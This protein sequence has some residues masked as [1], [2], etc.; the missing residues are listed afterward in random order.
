MV[1]PSFLFWRSLSRTPSLF[2]CLVVLWVKGPH[3]PSLIP[4]TRPFPPCPDHMQH[5]EFQPVNGPRSPTPP[6]VENLTTTPQVGE[7]KHSVYELVPPPQLA[8]Y[9]CPPFTYCPLY[10]PPCCDSYPPFLKMTSTPFP[11]IRVPP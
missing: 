6:S 4:G 2:K 10:L 8:V 7:M 3:C 9:F 1:Q 11:L 5:R